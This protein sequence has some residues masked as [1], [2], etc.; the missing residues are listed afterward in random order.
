MRYELDLYIIT[1]KRIIGLEEVAFLDRHISE[2]ALE[3]VQE[4]N[5]KTS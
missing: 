4:V 3:K 2:C 5:A 1:N